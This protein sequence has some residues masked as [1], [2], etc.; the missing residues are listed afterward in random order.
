MNSDSRNRKSLAI[1][2]AVML[3][4]MSL[5]LSVSMDAGAGPGI[6]PGIIPG[7]PPWPPSL[8]PADAAWDSGG[9]KCIVAGNETSGKAPGAWYLDNAANTWHQVTEGSDPTFPP[10]N[11]VKNVNTGL[12]YGT[13]QAA[14]NA[15]S[16][17][18]ALRIWSGTYNEDI[19]VDRT[20]T[21]TGNGSATTVIS[22]SSAAPVVRITAAGTRL[23]GFNVTGGGTY[24][25][26]L[27]RE[28]NNCRI[29]NNTVYGNG[30]GILLEG[31]SNNIVRDNDVR[32]NELGL[33]AKDLDGQKH[34]VG[35][36]MTEGYADT[37]AMF[38]MDMDA[39]N[40]QVMHSFIA[41]NLD[42]TYPSYNTLV[43]DLIDPN[44]LYG[45]TPSGGT[46]GAGTIFRMNKDGSGYAVLHIFDRYLEGATSYCRLTQYNNVLYGTASAGGQYN[47]GTIFR[48]NTDGSGFQ[49]MHHFQTGVT[50]GRAPYGS[51]LL[52]GTTLYG[53]T[54]S[55]GV[56][57]TL[58]T[59]FKI[60]VDGTG[61]VLIKSFGTVHGTAPRG[62]LIQS[63][64]V[65]YGMTYSGGAYNYGTIFKV[66]KDGSGYTVLRDFDGTND[67]R[68]PYGDL[69]LDGTTL[70]GMT[71]AGGVNTYGTLFSIQT[72]GSGFS[73]LHSFAAATGRT[74]YGSLVQDATNLYGM[75]YYGGPNYG[76]VFSFN[77]ATS[78]HAVLYSFT[79]TS[80]GYY[81]YGSPLLDGS[82]LFGMAMYGGA[83]NRGTIFSINT[84]GSSFL[85]LYSFSSAATGCI[86]PRG[87]AVQYGDML[88]GMTQGGG[89]L[90]YGAIYRIKIDGTGFG[91][92]YNFT[93]GGLA[94]SQPYGELIRDG[95][96]LYGM[97]Y[98]GGSSGRGVVF[99][100]NTDGTGYFAIK[101]FAASPDGGYPF[102]GL[103]KG[104]NTLYGM[105]YQGGTSNLGTVFKVDVDGTGYAKL[106]DFAGG[107]ADGSTP[108]GSLILDNGILY[109]MTYNGGAS[110]LGTVFRIR[111]DGTEY[112][113]LYNF[114]GGADG[115]YPYS[116][117]VLSE[118]VLYGTTY[119]GGPTNYGTIFKINADGSN[120]GVIRTFVMAN[121]YSIYPSLTLDGSLLYGMAMYGGAGYGTIFSIDKN[122]YSFT[123]MRSF[124]GYPNDAGN[125]QYNRLTIITDP[126]PAS[127]GNR[128][129]HNN[130]IGNVLQARDDS[131]A[132]I[133]DDGYPSGGN[134]WAT[135]SGVDANS[136]GIGDTPYWIAGTSAAADN[137]PM[138]KR[139]GWMYP[140]P[141]F[142][143]VAWDGVNQ[144]FWVCS[145]YSSGA[146]S[147]LYYIPAAAPN[148]M[149]PVASPPVRFTALAVDGQGR[150]LLGGNG[151]QYMHYYNPATDSW[152]QFAENAA[153]NMYDWN[154]N[155]ITFNPNDGRF[156]LVGNLRSVASAVA[157]VTDTVPL[158]AASKCYIDTSGFVT[159]AAILR[160]IAWN[161]GKNY[162]IAVGDGVYRLEPYDGNPGHMLTWFWITGGE[163]GGPSYFDISWDTDGWDEA[164][165]VGQSGP[166]GNYWRYNHTDPQVIDVYTS[167]TASRYGA[168]AM[169]PPSSPKWLLV[170]SNIEMSRAELGKGGG[171]G[172]GMPYIL[173]MKMWKASDSTRPNLLDKQVDADTTYTF[174]VEGNYTDDLGNDIWSDLT[175]TVAAWF[176][177]FATGSS[178]SAGDWGND[179][180]RTRQF[181]LTYIPSLD[182]ASMTYPAPLSGIQEFRIHSWW[183][184]PLPHGPDGRTHTAM[185]NVTFGPQTW[186]ADGA[187]LTTPSGGDWDKDLAL[188]D[189]GSWDMQ[190]HMF[191]ASDP[192][193]R[194]D[195]SY[196]EFGVKEFASITSTGSP[197]A[198]GPPATDGLFM[199]DCTIHYT[200]NTQ[201]FVTVSIP[202]LHQNGDPLN[203]SL[204]PASNLYVRSYHS[205]A[206][207]SSDIATPAY[208]PGPGQPLCVWGSTGTP[209]TA[210]IDGTESSGP[211]YSNYTAA[212]MS[213]PF[214][215]TVFGWW[216]D[217]PAGV[218][219]GTY[220]ATI[221]LG[222]TD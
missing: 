60:E 43:R 37:G 103:V 122:T 105:T 17:G 192:S 47:Y 69:T 89:Y 22:G 203:P 106:H 41:D 185:L 93:S 25:G 113:V 206:S 196:A 221:I 158:T 26:V 63:G 117:L 126:V 91:L 100:I 151:L 149:V 184:D 94:G 207:G 8:V 157:F 212:A 165:I 160:S 16:S 34:I 4:S 217:V 143:S 10:V 101:S 67:G 38:R 13:I 87:N 134:H 119:S 35:I 80:N 62:S 161:P 181:N 81:P 121:G 194:F 138:M 61:F 219:Q 152:V 132:N 156:Y 118:G 154:V 21:I 215:Y 133:W 79:L 163:P 208:F 174:L 58:G 209:I 12:T 74:P 124:T 177:N 75:C 182:F 24:P 175:I 29:D 56:N 130:F 141:S 190:V 202:D 131:A 218:A 125:P 179:N 155:G 102:G 128:I 64:T 222:V 86:T 145:Q 178:S 78:T 32:Y 135:Y 180:Y 53:M 150:V 70:Y 19:L 15:A 146:R 172:F 200:T 115:R 3:V 71:S 68:Y 144:R 96:V 213:L 104:G 1:V 27:V 98:Y 66:N 166:A 90:G 210:P 14:I 33:R 44:V 9:G 107:A 95:S 23:S 162:A 31:A 83:L 195:I 201:Y 82:K 120:Y 18:H 147:S 167:S 7:S 216:I 57:S 204:I 73:V 55:G 187:G 220:R 136:D 123:V 54:S 30:D 168:C 76:T 214:E 173:S 59:I 65:L 193:V 51:L 170:V 153:G 40:Y 88:Y 111:T 176:D 42:G 5:T 92:M 49:V 186:A 137:N 171:D 6:V 169:K 20:L 52:D 36:T 112:S 164:G 109:G 205:L 48:M 129:S 46:Y 139:S 211:F 140:Y 108:Y 50:N 127:G 99:K 142:A 77:K 199:G 148:I 198:T 11:L 110:N 116:S 189:A 45:T 72:G 28:T 197:S 114:L 2:Q 191:D 85:R 188:N 39:S 159:G 84:D 183:S 97:T